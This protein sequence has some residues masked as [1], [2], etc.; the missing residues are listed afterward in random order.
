METYFT[1]VDL[2]NLLSR[3]FHCDAGCDEQCQSEWLKT[4]INDSEET[5]V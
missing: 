4:S 2:Q 5:L 3:L 1:W